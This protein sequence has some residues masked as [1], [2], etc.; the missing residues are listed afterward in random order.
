M[1]TK[2]AGLEWRIAFTQAS[3]AVRIHRF[4]FTA[5]FYFQF[6]SKSNQ[7]QSIIVHYKVHYC[8][9]LFFLSPFSLFLWHVRTHTEGINLVLT[10]GGDT[11]P[12]GP[13]TAMSAKASKGTVIKPQE[14]VAAR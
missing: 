13:V 1:I 7:P 14:S 10:A 8:I 9:I 11:R 12:V 4:D 3:L 6:Q 5:E 2:E